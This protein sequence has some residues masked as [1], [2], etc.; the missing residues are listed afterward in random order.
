MGQAGR[1]EGG[2]RQ[3][4]RQRRQQRRRRHRAGPQARAAT[5]RRVGCINSRLD[6]ALTAAPARQ[7]ASAGHGDGR[8]PA[9]RPSRV[10]N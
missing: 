7:A 5:R 9:C 6:M 2:E 4:R 10:C 1:S 3:R 8:R